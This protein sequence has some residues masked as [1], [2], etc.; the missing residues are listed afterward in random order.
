MF[1]KKLYDKNCRTIQRYGRGMKGRNKAA[2][3]RHRIKVNDELKMKLGSCSGVVRAFIDG[4]NTS[5]SIIAAA[6]TL[7]VIKNSEGGM[8]VIFEV[9]NNDVRQVAAITTSLF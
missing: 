3:E 9:R 1:F 7:D 4:T 2:A 6:E 5:E 8:D